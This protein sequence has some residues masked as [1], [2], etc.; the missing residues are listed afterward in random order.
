M[1]A[2]IQRSNNEYLGS[3]MYEAICAEDRLPEEG[4]DEQ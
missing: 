4:G 3:V 1:P 2:T